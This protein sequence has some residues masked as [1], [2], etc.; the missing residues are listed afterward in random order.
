MKI[1]LA[2]NADLIYRKDFMRWEKF[3]GTA[4]HAAANR[5]QVVSLQLLLKANIDLHGV[6]WGGRAAFHIAIEVGNSPC[7][8]VPMSKST[9]PRQASYGRE[10]FGAYSNVNECD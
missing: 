1:L 4:L 10:A 9:F 8:T 2:Q 7:G 6:D 5:G 3:G